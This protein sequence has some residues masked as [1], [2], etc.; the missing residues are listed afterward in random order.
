MRERKFALV[1]PSLQIGG[2]EKV[3]VEL[4]NGFA[5]RNIEIDLIVFDI[6]GPLIKS[7]DPRVRVV[8]LKCSSYRIAVF[9]LALYFSVSRPSSVLTSMYATGLVAIIGRLVSTFKPKI[10]VGAHNSLL[11][12]STNADNWK[13]KY[14]L[15]ALAK[16]FFPFA[17]SIVAVSNGVERELRDL[18]DVPAARVRTIYNPVIGNKFWQKLA[19]PRFHEWVDHT[20]IR[21]F[22]TIV[23]VGRLVEQK[24]FDILLHALAETRQQSDIR[25]II[26]GDGPLRRELEEQA[27][28]LGIGPFVVFLGWLSNPYSHLAHA[29]L[30]VLSS[31][32]EGLGNVLIEALA[33]GCPIVAT[34]CNFGPS[35]ILEAGK[36]GLLVKVGSV[37]DLSEKISIALESSTDT[38]AKKDA[39][40]VRAK[41]FTIDIAVE[42][43]LSLFSELE[44]NLVR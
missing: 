20:I 28:S 21:T 37:V 6:R 35:E 8:D 26:I 30:F 32:W 12:K 2:A 3:I 31:R 44:D 29:D 15:L 39:R 1:L 34:D 4:A 38:E 27:L 5:E 22:K 14:L 10:V 24:G 41:Q 18:I 13:D 7:L 9:K 36:H 17:D 23:A 25:L 11:F 16:F 43:Y 40:I 42:R 33:S 19:E